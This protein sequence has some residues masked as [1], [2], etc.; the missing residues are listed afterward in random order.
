MGAYPFEHCEALI[1]CTAKAGLTCGVPAMAATGRA[2]ASQSSGFV[3]SAA[4]A[5][6]NRVGL[7]LYTNGGR[8]IAPFQGGILCIDTSPLRRSVQVNS[9]GTN[10]QCDGQFA[11]DMNAFAAGVAGGNPAPFLKVIGNRINA[12]WW[13]RDSQATGSFLSDAAEYSICP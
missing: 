13:G 10:N 9:G 2:S 5:R 11:L 8:G 1:Y 12:Q 3:L 4:P 6:G 7:V